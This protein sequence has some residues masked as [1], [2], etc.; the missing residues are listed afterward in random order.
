M[1]DLIINIFGVDSQIFWPSSRKYYA[2]G[3]LFRI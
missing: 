1:D 3:L 2:F